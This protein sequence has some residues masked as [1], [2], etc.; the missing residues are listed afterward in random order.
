[1]PVSGT[2]IFE[3][4]A[5]LMVAVHATQLPSASAVEKCVV[6]LPKMS[7]CARSG[8]PWPSLSRRGPF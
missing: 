8:V 4:K 3:P 1:M 7:L 2:T 5:V 6:C